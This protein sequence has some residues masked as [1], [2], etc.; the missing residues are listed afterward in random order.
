V[1]KECCNISINTDYRHGC[2]G[3]GSEYRLHH[4]PA[5]SVW[6]LGCQQDGR[7]GRATLTGRNSHTAAWST[8]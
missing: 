4:H 8:T 6:G 7:S 2:G 5:L 3:C 1:L